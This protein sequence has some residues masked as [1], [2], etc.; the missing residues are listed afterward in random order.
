ML[1]KPW[2][3]SVGPLGC[4]F[5]MARIH[6][7]DGNGGLYRALVDN[8]I[9]EDMEARGISYIHVYCVDNIL[10]KMADP[11]FVGF[12]VSKGAD[13]GA[14]GLDVHLSNK[15]LSSPFVL[16]VQRV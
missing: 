10:V 14:K 7:Q 15:D 11:V 8:R 2:G 5:F 3:N 13:C 6:L 16:D 9:L 1:E 12:C 4:L